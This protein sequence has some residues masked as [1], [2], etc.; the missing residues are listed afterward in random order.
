MLY[1]VITLRRS[2][3]QQEHEQHQPAAPEGQRGQP[4]QRPEQPDPFVAP[5]NP[6]FARRLFRPVETMVIQ[7]RQQTLQIA[8]VDG[9]AM[10]A[11][12]AGRRQSLTPGRLSKR[13]VI[14]SRLFSNA[15][16]ISSTQC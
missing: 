1:E 11:A 3:Q 2:G 12:A 10:I 8:V 4:G 7:A 6:G 13:D 16:T 5:A 14:W 15:A 9:Q